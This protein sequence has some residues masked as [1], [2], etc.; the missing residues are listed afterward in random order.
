MGHTYEA[1][2]RFVSQ[3]TN[4]RC[5]GGFDGTQKLPKKRVKSKFGF[6]VQGV[7]KWPISHFKKVL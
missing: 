6:A 3:Y 4:G 7:C 2:E 5:H 1:C